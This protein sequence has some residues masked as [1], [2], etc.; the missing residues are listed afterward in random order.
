MK[1]DLLMLPCSE[2]FTQMLR[3]K[4]AL[5]H[6]VRFGTC[7]SFECI[8][9]LALKRCGDMQCTTFTRTMYLKLGSEISITQ[10]C[11]ISPG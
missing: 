9:T 3:L 11:Y 1:P 6:I 5:T 10:K 2:D 7:S 8:S 4:H